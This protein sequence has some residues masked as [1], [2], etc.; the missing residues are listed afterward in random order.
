MIQQ[1]AQVLLVDD[2]DSL[3]Q[4]LAMRLEAAGYT[5][6]TARSGA[7]ALSRIAEQAPAVVVSDLRMPGMD[8]IELFKRI[9]AR[10]NQLPVII[11]TAHGTIP[12]AVMATQ[13]GLFAFLTKPVDKKD[14]LLALEKALQ[15]GSNTMPSPEEWTRGI[16]TQS[17]KMHELLQQAR[18]V[19]A[20]DANVLICGASGTGKE[21]LAQAV[22]KA[23]PRAQGPW[24]ALNC[25]AI[26]QELFESEL[27]GH[28][29]G[30]FTGAHVDKPGLI[31]AADSGTLFLDEIGDMPTAVQAK[32]LRVLQEKRV[33]PVGESRDF[34]VNMRVIAATHRDL[35]Q[36]VAAGRFR[37]DLFYRV[38]V[39]TLALPTLDER[40]EDIPLLTEHFL[41]QIA[42][43]TGQAKKHLA[44]DA[45][46][47]LVANQWPGN[48]RE[49]ANVIERCAA[50]TAA[51]VISQATV[52]QAT[53]RQESTPLSLSDAKKAFERDYLIQTLKLASGNVTLAASYADRNRSDFHKLLKKHGIDVEMFRF[54][55]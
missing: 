41:A 47:T 44:Q 1:R 30:A 50:L 24:I 38:N 9:H 15:F 19:A 22:H 23:S 45:M 28:V 43:R 42:S 20:S 26:P 32:L 7:E 40:K 5:V 2:D 35:Q 18:L 37:E 55:S 8:G 53:V 46:Q 12:D 31:R 16:V 21:L 49:L 13:S 3:L 11:L 34:A 10:W 33:R 51:P 52:A 54:D 27:F 14:L 4:L 36:E 6:R 48:I 39:V 29:K 17:L 25:A